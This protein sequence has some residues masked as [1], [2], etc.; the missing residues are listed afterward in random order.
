VEPL[1]VKGLTAHRA[2]GFRAFVIPFLDT[3]KT[4]AV[5]AGEVAVG[6][7]GIAD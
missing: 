4:K 5:A 7:L 1:E 3:T 2:S 6:G